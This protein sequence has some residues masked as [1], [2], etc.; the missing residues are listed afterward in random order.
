MTPVHPRKQRSEPRAVNDVRCEAR[1]G[2]TCEAG[3]AGQT[4]KGSPSWTGF[5]RCST[6][7]KSAN[8][9]PHRSLSRATLEV[10][11]HVEQDPEWTGVDITGWSLFSVRCAVPYG[12][13]STTSTRRNRLLKGAAFRH[14]E[15]FD[16]GLLTAPCDPQPDLIS[17]P[18]QR[19]DGAPH[20]LDSGTASS[21]S[22]PPQAPG[23]HHHAPAPRR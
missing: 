4:L 13:R 23:T 11:F 1:R 8:S 7:L 16:S 20:A 3:H 10:G 18:N 14:P 19:T 9:L 17:S 2:T 12:F 22:H 6:R 5:S 15:S 21:R